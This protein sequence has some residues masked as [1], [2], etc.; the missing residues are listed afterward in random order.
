MARTVASEVERLRAEAS[1]A[2]PLWEFTKDLIDEFID[3]SL[4]YR[5]SGHPG[6]SRSKV[7]LLLALM[8]SGAMRWDLLRPWRRFGD[9]FVLSAGHTVPLIYATLAALNEAMRA[10]H[11]RTRHERF[12]FPFD[13][14]YALVWEDLLLLRRNQGLPGHAEM[15]GKTLFLKWNTGPSGHGMPPTVGEAVALKIAGCEEVKVFAVE[16]EG[17]LTPGASHETRNSAWGLGLSNLVFL[18]D[19]NDFGIDENAVSSVV[20]GGPRDWFAPYGWRVV[21]TERGSEWDDVTNVV[22]EAARGS[23][24]ERVPS[25]GWFR[26]RKGRGYLKYDYKSHGSAHAMNSE[27]FW[28]LRKEFM[29]KYGVEYEGVDR[30][31]PQEPEAIRAQARRNLGIAVSALRARPDI[32]EQLSDR[33]AEIAATVPDEIPTFFLGGRAKDIF[34]DERITDV[35]RYPESLFAKP[36]EKKPNRAALAAWGAWVNSYARKEYGRPLFIAMSADLAE[37]TNIAGFMKGFEDVEGWGWYQR[38][39]N[40]HGALLP[41]QITE[42]TNSGVACGIASVNLAD[43]P[44][45][46]FNGFWGACSTYGAFSYL[47]YGE[48]RLFS[49]LAQDCEL[50]VGKVLWIAGHSGPETAEDSRTHFG[51]FETGVTQL[52]PDGAVIDLHP[53]EHNEVPVVLGAA[54]RQRAPIVALHLTRPNVDIPD[55]AAL[56]M[57][58]HLEAA[59]GAYL[60]RPYRADQAKMGTV[61]VQ[62]TSTTANVVKILAQLDERGINVKIVAA[63]SPQLYALQS[64]AYRD[65]IASAPERLDAMVVSNRARRVMRDWIDHPIVAEYSLTSDWDDRWRTGGTVDE[66]I[67]EAHLDAP[68]LLAGIERFAKER[69]KRLARIRATVDALG[70]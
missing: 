37:S 16:G 57:A 36:G 68:H 41:Q 47:K 63:I 3:L 45:G 64:Q 24:P 46:E 50:K 12:A 27:P 33:L 67:A 58:S 25:V 10:R 48:M 5:Q 11:E 26:T 13:G 6:G 35:S 39:T 61:F 53:W 43:D 31:A 66:V 14:R 34:D 30:P 20:H 54:L 70:A 60:I 32:V 28:Q 62:G 38:D 49:Q 8:L 7:H 56:G 40:P 19:W 59:R 44:F 23:N 9:R 17:G 1:A 51:I 21:G 52:F 22:L 55:R 15:A 29:R 4:N 65:A 69:A 18:L 2:F 42:F